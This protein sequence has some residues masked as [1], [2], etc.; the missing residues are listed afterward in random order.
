[1]E[2][3]VVTVRKDHVYQSVAIPPKISI[4]IFRGYLNGKSTLM[5]YDRHPALQSKCNKVF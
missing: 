4:S 5:I 1:M 2:I 3:I